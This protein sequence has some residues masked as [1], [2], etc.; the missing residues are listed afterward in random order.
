MSNECRLTDATGLIVAVGTRDQMMSSLK[1]HSPDGEY[2]VVGPGIDAK[3]YKVDG[4]VYPAGGQVDSQ[5]LPART[6]DECVAAFGGA[7]ELNDDSDFMKELTWLDEIDPISPRTAV[8][9]GVEKPAFFDRLRAAGVAHLSVEFDGSGDAGY[10]EGITA[11]GPEGSKL[12]LR[13]ALTELVEDFVCE[14]LPDGWEI[15]EGSFG[16]IEF[17]VASGTMRFDFSRRYMEVARA[18]WEE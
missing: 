13:R 16:T 10:V 6:R 12:E 8:S 7:N 4:V 9:Q 17:D 14:R 11:V 1:R 3:F 15:D 5:M 2:A 18:T